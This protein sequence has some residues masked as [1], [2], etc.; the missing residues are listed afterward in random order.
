MLMSIPT[1]LAAGAVTTKDLIDSG[2]AA[3]G[4]DAAIAAVL[5]CVSAL[6]ALTVMMRMLRTWSLTPFVIYRLVLGSALLV[7]LYA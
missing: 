4:A 7:W 3:L 2:D 6:L 5:A 1:I